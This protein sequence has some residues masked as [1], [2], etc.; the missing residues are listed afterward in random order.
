[1]M[2]CKTLLGLTAGAV[3][4]F[5]G[6]LAMAGEGCA[7]CGSSAKASDVKAEYST[8]NL[9][10]VAKD[11]GSFN[12]L[13]TAAK[14][15]GLKETLKTG[16]PLT[17]LAPTDEAFAALPEGTLDSLLQPENVEQLKAIL[18]YHVIDG[19]VMSGDVVKLTEAGSLSGQPIAIAVGEDGSVTFGS[20]KLLKAD[21]EADNGVI[22]VIDAVLLPP[23]TAMAE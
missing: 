16:G 1:M 17:I 19:K 7:S 8:N 23:Q 13:L 4:A 5:S 11:A 15:A 20:A 21:V 2:R 10:A 9:W 18:L 3:L 12:T 22:H 6:S 14:A